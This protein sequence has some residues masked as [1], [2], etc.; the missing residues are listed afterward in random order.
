MYIALLNEP[1]DPWAQLR[2]YEDMRKDKEK[3]GAMTAFTGTMRDFN[4]GDTVHAMFLEH[5]PGMT[6]AALA[7]IAG[8]ALH[9]WPLHDA[10]IVHRVGVIAPGETIVLTAAWS[11]HRDAAFLGCR[12]L[13]ETLKHQAPFWKQETLANGQQRW[14]DGQTSAST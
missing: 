3:S 9:Q 11:A 7:H 10:L 14:V 6:E 12:Y 13:I 1:F 8:V 5:Y 2:T 4:L